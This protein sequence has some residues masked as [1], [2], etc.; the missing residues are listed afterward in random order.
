MHRPTCLAVLACLA[1]V[2]VGS[3]VPANAAGPAFPVL[4]MGDSY[5]A[6]N[7]AGSYINPKGCYRSDK[8]YA[9]LYAAALRRSPYNQATQFTNV[10]C[11]GDT[12]NGFFAREKG[13]APQ[14]NA[15]NSS[16]GLILLTTG[17]DDVD[18]ADIVKQCLI[19]QTR[20]GQK[21]DSHLSSAEKLI[22]D[23]TLVSRVRRVLSAIRTKANPL[24]TIALLGY[25]YLEK[26]TT[27]AFSFPHHKP[28]QV[29]RRL[30]ALEDLGDTIQQHIV[31][32]LNASNRTN[33]FVFVKTKKLFEGHELSAT[34]SSRHPWF[35][36]PFTTIATSTWYHPNPRGW[37]EEA[38]LLLRD[39][40]IPKQMPV[41]SPPPP[42]PPPLPPPLP[43]VPSIGPTLIGEANTAANAFDGDRNFAEW[44]TSTSQ[45]VQ[46]ETTLPGDISSY[47][48]VVLLL[49]QSFDPNEASELANYMQRGGRVLAIGEHSGNPQFEVADQ[50]INQL[51]G[52]LGVGLSLDDDS[53]DEGDTVTSV[54]APSPLTEAVA[55]VGYNWASTI[56]FSDAAQQ[57][58]A[59]ADGYNTLIGE[60]SVGPGAFFV[61]GDSNLFSD[62]NDGFYS[63]YGNSQLVAD[64]CP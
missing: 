12:T 25:P 37:S 46:V 32:Q 59:T 49:N 1:L 43:P 10:A 19:K 62:N 9:A 27:Y 50:A 56:T 60:Q 14:L 3:S 4:V 41:P 48:C 26:D 51:A 29:G 36:K 17:G 15:V 16:Y 61:S 54:I 64:L 63:E 39:S 53:Y 7:G 45:G 24:A 13:Q 47:R 38:N 34:H 2:P 6:G 55:A 8:D 21:C 42:P 5:S 58:V 52:A 57:I 40:R 18:F 28:V 44:Q 20:D 33:S 35:V 30:K 31:S 11:S 22:K 23:G